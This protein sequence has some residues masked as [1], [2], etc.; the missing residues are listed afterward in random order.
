MDCVV[1]NS[2]IVLCIVQSRIA[3]LSGLIPNRPETFGTFG[4]Q[5][6]ED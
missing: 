3:V 4:I 6:L 1:Q 2:E 5:I